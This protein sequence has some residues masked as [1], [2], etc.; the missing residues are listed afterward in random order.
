MGVVEVAAAVGEQVL[1]AASKW[2]VTA[3]PRVD[4][5]PWPTTMMPK[6]PGEC[7]TCR[8]R[9]DAARCAL[10]AA[11]VLH[12]REVQVDSPGSRPSG[13]GRID[14]VHVLKCMSELPSKVM[15]AG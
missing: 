11:H 9:A 15:R 1:V 7:A 4:E 2:P 12:I 5:M 8:L 14:E 3:L 10:W 13:R 6:R